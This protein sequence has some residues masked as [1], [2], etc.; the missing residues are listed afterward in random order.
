[1]KKIIF[2]ITIL[3]VSL[4]MVCVLQSYVKSSDEAYPVRWT[5]HIKINSLDEIDSVLDNFVDEYKGK[6]HELT[7]INDEGDKHKVSTYRQYRTLQDEGYYPATNWDILYQFRFT[8]NCTSLELLKKAK[9]SKISYIADFDITDNPLEVLP[10]TLDLINTSYEIE[11]AEGAIKQSKTWQEYDPTSTYTVK[12]A[13]SIHI[14][15]HEET[16][17]GND[18]YI[19]VQA[20]GDFN[21]DS[22]EDVLLLVTHYIKGASYRDCRHELLTRFEEDG[23]LI[24]LP[25]FKPIKYPVVSPDKTQIVFIREVK[26]CPYTSD[27]GWFVFDYDEIWAM[28]ANGLN[29]RRLIVNN[30]LDMLDDDGKLVLSRMNDFLGSFGPV[31]F[32]PDSKHIYFLCQNSASN[33]ILY[34]ANVDG[35][36][37]KKL[38]YAHGLAG[39]IGGSPQ[40]QHYGCIVAYMKKSV[41]GQPYKW[42]TVLLSPDGKEIKEISP[43]GVEKFEFVHTS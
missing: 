31:Y 41:E 18:I 30:Y 13:H 15:T 38:G 34:T 11:K 7:L 5:E 28:D 35:S 24:H 27:T 17:G 29:Q 19:T 6:Q 3:S 20:W 9:P 14:E 40:S 10:P 23:P 12:D 43:E 33:A 2:F 4:T 32:S 42:V 26:E 21:N 37:I 8:E 1:M 25:N 36:S 39:I 16:Y 22:T